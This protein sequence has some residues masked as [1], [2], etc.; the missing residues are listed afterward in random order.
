MLEQSQELLISMENLKDTQRLQYDYFK[1]LTTLSLTAIGLLIVAIRSDSISFSLVPAGISLV[2]LLVCLV[3]ALYAMPVVGNSILFLTGVRITAT[4]KVKPPEEAKK[5]LEDFSSKYSQT[6]DRIHLS[7][8]ITKF[9]L[10][11]GAF[12]AVIYAGLKLIE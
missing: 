5:D 11:S 9:S 4:S 1:H 12:M 8:K 7:D 2:S 10:L 6:L 3:T